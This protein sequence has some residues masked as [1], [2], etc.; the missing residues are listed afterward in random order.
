MLLTSFGRLPHNRRIP[1]LS[2]IM[3][4]YHHIGIKI[5]EERVRL[6][7]TQDALASLV[8]LT[9][10]SITNIEAGRQKMLL[11]TFIEI[12][13]ALNVPPEKLLP[14]STPN[15]REPFEPERPLD[16]TNEDW[17]IMEKAMTGKFIKKGKGEDY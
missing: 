7:L 12:A 11:E 16:V 14:S 17:Q 2:K 4:I 3:D 1:Q 8:S 9:R 5:R 13:E 6:H 10:S 15:A